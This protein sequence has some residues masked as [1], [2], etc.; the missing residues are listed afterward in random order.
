MHANEIKRLAEG[1]LSVALAAGR[2]QM[3]HFAAGV[4]VAIKDDQSPVTIADHESEAII[5]EGLARLAPGVAV[6]AEEEV[7]AGRIP[8]ITGPFFLVD[9]LD[10]IRGPWAHSPGFAPQQA[11]P[12]AHAG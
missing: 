8:P 4:E 11:G 10:G 9:P 12:A 3:A 7:N 6:V 2:A 1:L 5:L